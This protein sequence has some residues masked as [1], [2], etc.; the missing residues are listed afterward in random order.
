[1]KRLTETQKYQL[2]D[3]KIFPEEEIEK[4]FLYSPER[5]IFYYLTSEELL[6]VLKNEDIMQ[7]GFV[8]ICGIDDAKSYGLTNLRSRL[9]QLTPDILKAFQQLTQEHFGG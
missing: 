7:Y 1:M 9:H 6:K 5:K 8:T 2:R 3:Y 4:V